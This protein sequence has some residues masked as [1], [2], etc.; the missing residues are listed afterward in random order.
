MRQMSRRPN[1]GI[2][3]SHFSFRSLC[4]AEVASVASVTDCDLPHLSN[5]IWCIQW[6]LVHW[7]I[8]ST[9]NSR[10]LIL[11]EYPKILSKKEGFFL[12]FSAKIT[13]IYIQFFGER[14]PIRKYQEIKTCYALETGE[15]YRDCICARNTK[16]LKKYLR[17]WPRKS[18]LTHWPVWLSDRWMTVTDHKNH[19]FKKKVISF[20]CNR[21]S[22]LC[23]RRRATVKGVLGFESP[24]RGW[25]GRSAGGRQKKNME[26][27]IKLSWNGPRRPSSACFAS[28]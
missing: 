15:Y 10:N 9:Q 17:N 21:R 28:Y 24:T 6:F 16:K 13:E 19:F 4:Q 25:V 12:I 1:L 27:L 18:V 2:L 3:L 22:G 26:P 14:A 8:S 20:L 23:A 7:G 11:V 5:V